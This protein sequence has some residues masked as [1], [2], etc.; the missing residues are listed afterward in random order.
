MVLHV[1][2]NIQLNPDNSNLQGKTEKVRVSGDSSYRGF[3]LSRFNC[4]KGTTAI[5]PSESF[6]WNKECIE[7][8]T[9]H[10]A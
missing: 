5:E 9:K 2:K 7:R 6:F 3:E 4:I 1:W 8:F 10:K